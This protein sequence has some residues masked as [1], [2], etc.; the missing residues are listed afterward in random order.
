MKT[1]KKFYI[2]IVLVLHRDHGFLRVPFK[3]QKY[4][5]F[6]TRA[7]EVKTRI[8]PRNNFFLHFIIFLLGKTHE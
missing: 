3:V 8:S 4:F 1:F 7:S 6:F 2:L 5:Q